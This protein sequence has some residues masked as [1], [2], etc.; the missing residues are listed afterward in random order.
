MV[1]SLQ[2]LQP[3]QMEDIQND[4]QSSQEMKRL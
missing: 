3:C 4:H 1:A 2:K